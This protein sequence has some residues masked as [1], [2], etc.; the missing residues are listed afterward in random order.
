M[1]RALVGPG[2]P[3][4]GEQCHRSVRKKTILT[5]GTPWVDE[6]VRPSMREKTKLPI[7][8]RLTVLVVDEA[9]QR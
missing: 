5:R 4:S 9:S 2:T 7:E 8:K 3:S 1:T 6:G